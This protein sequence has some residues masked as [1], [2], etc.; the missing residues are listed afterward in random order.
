MKT[1]VTIYS[2]PGCH[3]CEEAK[4]EIRAANCA[5]R[6]V[7]EE[8]NIENDPELLERYKDDIPVITFDGVEVFRHRLE[9]GEFVE[10]LLRQATR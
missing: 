1:R 10:A 4:G 7:L 9:S 6:Y 2:R 8:V 3:L 5:E